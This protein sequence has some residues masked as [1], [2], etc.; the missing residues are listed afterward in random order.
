MNYFA[1]GSLMSRAR[2]AELCPAAKPLHAATI[3]NHR[4]AFLGRSEQW[5]GGTAA[6]SLATGRQV[7]G[8]VYEIDDECR[9]AIE[10][11]GAPDGYVWAW[12]Q[13]EDESGVRKRVGLLVK[14]RGMDEAPPSAKY[15]D[16]LRR[17]WEEWGR[18]P[19]D[20]DASIAKSE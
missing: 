1:Y 18:D 19:A 6:I 14:V 2:L 12:T 5:G 16:V 7:W 3:P 10:R 17:A 8:G 13:V 4:L 15:L 20:F 9:A 11:S